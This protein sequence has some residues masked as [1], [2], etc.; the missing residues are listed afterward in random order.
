MRLGY[1]GPIVPAS[2]RHADF[3]RPC[4]PRTI[5]LPWRD[6]LLQLELDWVGVEDSAY[7]PV[8]FLHEGL[9]SVSLWKECPEQ[10]CRAHG[11]SGLVFSR[12][13][14]GRSTARPHDQRR[15]LVFMQRQAWEL[16]PTLL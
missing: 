10:L 6:K 1:T 11:L 13:G 2:A 9:V 16:L 15:R 8:V 14:Y 7:P 3:R 4:P 12:Y 5:E